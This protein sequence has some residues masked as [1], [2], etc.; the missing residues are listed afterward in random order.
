MHNIILTHFLNISPYRTN[1]V[2]LGFGAYDDYRNADC[3][4]LLSGGKFTCISLIIYIKYLSNYY[5]LHTKAKYY[6]LRI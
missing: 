6:F 4:N 2:V 3:I 1:D 5:H